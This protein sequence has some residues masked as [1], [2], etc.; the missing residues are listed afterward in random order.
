M[1]TYIYS[2]CSTD[3]QD[4]AQQLR[5]VNIYLDNQGVTPDGIFEEKEHGT[6]SAEERELKKVI[7][8]C[9]PG[10]RIIVSEFSRITRMGQEETL[11]IIKQ[12]QKKQAIIYCVKEG[13]SL[14]KIDKE[15]N[16]FKEFSDGL[17][18][19][20]ISGSAHLERENI[21]ARTKSALA[22]KKDIIK[23]DGF[24]IA[25]K[26]GRKVTQLGSPD[27]N[28][29]IRMLGTMASAK[30]RTAKAR[31]NPTFIQAYR[32]AV[33]LREKDQGNVT[34]A[35]ELNDI[36]LRTPRGFKYLPSSI[37]QLI[38]KGSNYSRAS[39]KVIALNGL[40]KT[41]GV[42]LRTKQD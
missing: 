24:F 27:F 18:T 42:K 4:Y 32:I 12:L 31:K 36:G 23:K 30:I 6:V 19:N 2:R 16:P 7:D 34:I 20:F 3:D 29:E 39:A 13:L 5:T 28:D 37:S 26:T 17:I 15:V 21:A 11:K 22:A 1:K 40:H 35:K 33:L 8:L 14:G 38:R 25:K 10:D 41:S 9:E